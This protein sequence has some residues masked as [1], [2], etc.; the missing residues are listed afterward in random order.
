MLQNLINRRKRVDL[1]HFFKIEDK[2]QTPSKRR[3][4]LTLTGPAGA[5]R[6]NS[7]KYYKKNC[8]SITRNNFLKNM[9]LHKF[10]FK[11]DIEFFNLV[12]VNTFKNNI[13]S[14]VFNLC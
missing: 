7:K 3:G 2:W 5:L 1:I 6:G 9:I 11:F 8:Q 12:T 13:D 4:T 10:D 14:K